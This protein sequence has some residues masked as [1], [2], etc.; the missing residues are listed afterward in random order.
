MKKKV[1]RSLLNQRHWLN[2]ETVLDVGCGRGLVAIEAARRV[3]FGRVHGVDIWHAADLSG[4]NPDAIRA[5]AAIAGVSDRLT[6]DTGDA[7]N[8]PYTDASFDVVSSMTAIHNIGN[9]EG[10]RKAISEVWRVPRPGGQVL[11]FDIRHAKAYLQQLRELG[12][13]DTALAGPV[14]LWGP[15]GW[16]ISATKPSSV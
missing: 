1:M 11:I 8:L 13:V 3:P 12:A 9:V 6:V 10:R 15:L 16:R 4:N 7:R 2:D 5:N 14:L